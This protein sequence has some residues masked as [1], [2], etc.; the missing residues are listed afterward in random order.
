M[1]KRALL[2]TCEQSHTAL[3]LSPA[4][5]ALQVLLLNR[6]LED[7]AFK[8]GSFLVACNALMGFQA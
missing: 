6:A 1:T 4:L 5:Q 8:M 7:R 3:L 2:S